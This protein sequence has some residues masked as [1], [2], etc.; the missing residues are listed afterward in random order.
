MIQDGRCGVCTLRHKPYCTAVP[1]DMRWPFDAL[2]A[3]VAGG[4]QALAE[5]FGW[6]TVIRARDGLTD[7]MADRLATR[8]GLHPNEVWSGWCDAALTSHDRQF[9]AEG[10]RPAWLHNQKAV[11]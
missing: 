11:A 7:V 5:R 6:K 10:W 2:V 9:V 1:K 4:E 8:C 3:A